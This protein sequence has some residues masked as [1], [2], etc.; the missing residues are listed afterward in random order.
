M[1]DSG[2]AGLEASAETTESMT[3]AGGIE[4]DSD[5]ATATEDSTRAADGSVRAAE[6]AIAMAEVA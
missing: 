4:A 5:A 2:G 1:A 6:R 3:R